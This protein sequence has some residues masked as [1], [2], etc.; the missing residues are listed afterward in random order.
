MLNEV[1]HLERQLFKNPRQPNQGDD[2]TLFL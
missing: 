1:T 2:D